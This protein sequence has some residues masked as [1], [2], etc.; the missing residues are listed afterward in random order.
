MN[1]LFSM[2]MKDYNPEG[3]VTARTSA[4]AVI[5]KGE[6]VLLVYKKKYGYYSFP[7]G[8][9]EEGEDDAA[10]L[11]REVA[12][13]TGYQ[14]EPDSIKPFGSVLV[15]HRDFFDENGIWEQPNRYYFAEISETQHAV[16]SDDSK[17]RH[18]VSPD[19]SRFRQALPDDYEVE[20]GYTAV[21]VKPFDAATHNRHIRYHHMA[22]QKDIQTQL[23]VMNREERVM[24]LVDFEV[25]RRIRAEREN[26]AIRDLKVEG[27]GEILEFV[28]QKLDGARSDSENIGAKTD[29]SYS[30][31]DHTK[32]VLGWA[33]RLYEATE[34]K[35]LIRRE[36]VMIASVFHDVGRSIEHIVGLPH[37]LAGEPI[38]RE[39][40]TGHGFSQ[41]RTDYI[42]Y[43]VTHHSDKQ[44]MQQQ[45]TDPGLIMLMEADML[46]DMGALGIVMDCMI[47][48]VRNPRAEFADCL[49]HMTRF[50][51]RLQHKCP[52]VTPAGI[53][54]WN[55]KTTLTD[56]FVNA[57]RRDIELGL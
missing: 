22:E 1:E 28:R 29:I 49:D 56:N 33:R 20:A 16:S 51:Q 37:A 35:D 7:G 2:D 41:E 15:R 54:L 55:D 11:Q 32:R 8:G 25:R 57:L 26:A 27:L 46:D 50:T 36:D 47:T 24:E 48:E 9:I 43:L 12:E 14:I 45:D 10:T 17:P 6:E 38:T 40:L 3:K 19:D 44:L 13:E 4:R 5:I 30:R 21:W 18:A 34:R 53:N 42:C 52:M 39:Y 23:V 31:F